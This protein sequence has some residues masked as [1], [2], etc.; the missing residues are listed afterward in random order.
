MIVVAASTE[1]QKLSQNT[2]N[3]TLYKSYSSTSWR[4][5]SILDT[6]LFHYYIYNASF[7]HYSTE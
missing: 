4:A 5:L 2:F 1:N 7:F 6:V 3:E